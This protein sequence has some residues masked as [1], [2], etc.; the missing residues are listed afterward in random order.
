M[1]RLQNYVS[2]K[3]VKKSIVT[4]LNIKDPKEHL[5]ARQFMR[6]YK[7]YIVSL[8]KIYALDGNQILFKNMK[9]CVPLG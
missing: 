2:I 7:S 3:T 4:L 6:V 8:D 5:L 9:A 1:E